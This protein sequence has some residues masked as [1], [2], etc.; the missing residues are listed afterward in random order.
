LF[1]A[2]QGSGGSI[3]TTNRTSSSFELKPNLPSVNTS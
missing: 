1:G 3:R 2:H